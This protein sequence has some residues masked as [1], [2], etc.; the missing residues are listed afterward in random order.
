[1]C[2]PLFPQ[3]EWEVFDYHLLKEPKGPID[4]SIY[5]INKTKNATWVGS[6]LG[7]SIFDGETWKLFSNPEGTIFNCK[8]IIVDTNGLPYF[9]YPNIFIGLSQI[10]TYKRGQFELVIDELDGLDMA[11]DDSNRLWIATVHG[12]YYYKNGKRYIADFGD[13]LAPAQYPVKIAAGRQGKIWYGWEHGL[14][15]YDTAWHKINLNNSSGNPLVYQLEVDKNGTAWGATVDGVFHY[16]FD[17]MYHFPLPLKGANEDITGLYF[18][19]ENTL[20]VTTSSNG[21][22]RLDKE[23]FYH[24]LPGENW[25]WSGLTSMGQ[26]PTGNIW[27]G[28]SSWGIYELTS[29]NGDYNKIESE[30]IQ[31]SF[32]I[33]INN[34]NHVFCNSQS[35]GL[36]VITNNGLFNFNAENGLVT[37]GLLDNCVDQQENLWLTGIQGI[38]YMRAGSDYVFE[39]LEPPAD[40]QYGWVR[41]VYCDSIGQIWFGTDEDG[42]LMFDGEKWA[43][44]LLPEAFPSMGIRDI[45]QLGN[46]NILV[47]T[48][49]KETRESF[50]FELNN[51][52]LTYLMVFPMNLAITSMLTDKHLNTWVAFAQKAPDALHT[53]QRINK[54]G[55]IDKYIEDIYVNEDFVVSSPSIF[56]IYEDK[57]GKIWFGAGVGA[58]SYSYE[59][60]SFTNIS[61]LDGLPSSNVRDFA[62]DEQGN[63]YFATSEDGI[64]KMLRPSGISNGKIVPLG[65]RAWPNPVRESVHVSLPGQGPANITLTNMQGQQVL[66]RQALGKN[67]TLNM[68]HLPK[69]V[70]LLTVSQNGN[71]ETKKIVVE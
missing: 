58:L 31:R 15:Y 68:G 20:W 3:Q 64:Y 8:K 22:F 53:I 35:G 9:Y 51:G 29:E 12:A 23:G 21:L 6:E 17:S 5:T 13:T 63:L 47:G 2:T 18:D 65:L 33:S 69:G 40:I 61:V 28:S 10:W 57:F 19:S 16:T 55:S 1:M 52:V 25:E 4:N 34:E 24:L 11:I 50:L 14:F 66:T 71:V 37:Y 39:K 56:S 32:D 7:L 38:Y 41:A 27:V 49:S 44:F 48:Y 54:E 42:L 43:Q 70:Y 46:G 67:A 45:S 60:N 62:E 59:T 26:S 36:N 30:D